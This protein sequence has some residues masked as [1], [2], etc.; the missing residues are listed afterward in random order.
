MRFGSLWRWWLA[1]G[2]LAI[3]GYFQLPAQGLG[4][5][6]GYNSLGFVS[7]VLILVSIRLHRPLRAKIWY[8][9]AL[10]QMACVVGDVIF[11][12]YRLAL[13]EEPYPSVADV[14][15]LCSYPMLIVGLFLMIR[16]GQRRLALRDMAGLIDAGI[17]GTGLGLVFW[18]FVMEPLAREAATSAGLLEQTISDA[19]PALDGLLLAL[20]AR[21]VLGGAKATTSSRLLSGAALALFAADTSFSVITLNSDY[22]VG[23]LDAGWLMAY[24]LWAAAALHPSMRDS[25]ETAV[26]GARSVGRR[27]LLLLAACSLIA[28]AMLLVPSVA[29]NSLDRIAIAI[30]AAALFLLV[31]LRMSGFVG[32]VQRQSH[33]LAEL[34]MR[35]ELTGLAN[36]RRFEE[37][38]RAEFATGSPQVALFDLNGFKDVNDRFGHAVGDELLAIVAGR[39]TG[40]LRPDAMVARMGGD[41]FAVLIPNASDRAGNAVVRRLAATFHA[42]VHAGQQDLLI[43][44]SIGIAGAE[45][46][47]GPMEVLRRADVAMYEAKGAGKPFHRYTTELDQ[48]STEQA[49]LGAELRAALDAGQFQLVYQPIVALPAGSLVSVEALVRWV[50]P[51]RGWVSPA[52]FIPVAEQNGLIVELGAWILRTACAQAADWR[53]RL[54]DR[55][56][57]RVNVNVSARQLAEPGF[58]DLVSAALADSGLPPSCLVI[59]VTETAVF[60]GGRAQE[61]LHELHALGVLVA[62]DDFGTGHSSLGLLQTVPVD[63]LKVDKSFVDNITMAGRHAVIAT[64]LIN[65]STGLGLTAVAEGVETAEQ[66]AELHRLGYRLAQGYHFGKPVAEPDFGPAEITAAV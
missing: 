55:A 37:A 39:I 10:G 20:L 35:D 54:G 53:A 5:S 6:I 4:R 1:V 2:V 44:A 33:Q 32:E 14:F 64:A 46:A 12:Y 41:E 49:R 38:L 36:R 42:P 27:R 47:D 11:D 3:V 18:V 8:W 50:H 25:G 16:G 17:V 9:F 13:H 7:A 19:Y 51:E 28:P 43:G 26:A 65:V 66:A 24:V 57:A 60:E 48:H 63:V 52:E 56:P 59:E 29:S 30:C 22:Q 23:F 61:T 21:L 40:A 15:Y 58:A 62:L 31:V 34:A 45:G